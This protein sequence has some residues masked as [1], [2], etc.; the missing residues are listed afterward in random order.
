MFYVHSPETPADATT[1]SPVNAPHEYLIAKYNDTESVKAL[2]EQAENAKDVAAIIV[3]PMIGSGGGIPATHDF[4]I[5]LRRLATEHGA[6][7]IFDE[8]MTSRMH[9]GGGI[10][11]QLPEGLRPDMTSLGKYIGGGMSFGAFGGGR[12]IMSMF[13]PR[14]NRLVHSGTFN[15]NVLTMAAGIAGMER[16][17]TPARAR[18]LHETGEAFRERL[19]RVCQGTNVQWTGCGSILCVHFLTLPADRIACP[20]D[21][22]HADLTLSNLLHLF[23]LERGYYIG[24]RGFIALSL[25]LTKEDLDGF[26]QSIEEF[27]R[28]YRPL[29]AVN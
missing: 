12:D 20:E 9:S 23:L 28:T 6:V 21:I 24:R 2:L 16:L 18:E 29:L 8:V 22:A 25:T 27:V 15:N 7:L 19:R 3:E 1:G 4:L 5:S 13:D 26:V 10:Q 14:Q 17:F 11:S